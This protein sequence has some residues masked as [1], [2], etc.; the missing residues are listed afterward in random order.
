MMEVLFF[1]QVNRLYG[2]RR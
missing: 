1:V 2:W